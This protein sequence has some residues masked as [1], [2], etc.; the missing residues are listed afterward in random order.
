VI[1]VTNP[2]LTK[3]KTEVLRS[4]PE[5]KRYLLTHTISCSKYDMLRWE[6]PD[7]TVTHCGYCIP[8]IYRRIAMHCLGL[9]DVGQ[10]HVNPFT[11]LASLSHKRTRDFK[12][13][14]AF[15]KRYSETSHEDKMSMT[16]SNGHL[17]VADQ[18]IITSDGSQ[19]SVDDFASC[20]DRFAHEALEVVH[21]L[22]SREILSNLGV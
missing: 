22:C 7:R 3:S 9:D 1:Y 12:A 20:Y 2:F 18:N 17:P 10:Y 11:Q 14:V 16:M 15:L 4:I 5:D 8:C 21:Q 13:L 19:Y 6:K